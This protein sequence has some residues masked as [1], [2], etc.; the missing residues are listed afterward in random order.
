MFIPK[1]HPTELIQSKG[2]R[3]LNLIFK[4]CNNSSSSSNN[5]LRTYYV[6]GTEFNA[7][8]HY[9]IYSLCLLCKVVLLSSFYG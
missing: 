3:I 9:F 6:P 8:I 7:Y 1:F 2:I 4:A 5:S